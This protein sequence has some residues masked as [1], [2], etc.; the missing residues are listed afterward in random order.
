MSANVFVPCARIFCGSSSK[1]KKTSPMSRRAFSFASLVLHMDALGV[2]SLFLN[3][4]I[5]EGNDI[6]ADKTHEFCARA[7]QLWASRVVANA[8]FDILKVGFNA[9]CIKTTR[10]RLCIGTWTIYYYTCSTPTDTSPTPSTTT[11][12]KLPNSL[13]TPTAKRRYFDREVTPRGRSTWLKK[14][15]LIKM[16]KHTFTLATAEAR[17]FQRFA[18]FRS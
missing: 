11:L 15:G 3:Q 8:Q 2:A 14:L 5:N 18:H 9:S 17:F 12:K 16:P 1:A 10:L 6:D 7:F 13:K 4:N